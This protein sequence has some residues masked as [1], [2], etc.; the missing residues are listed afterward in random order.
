MSS[1]NRVSWGSLGL[2]ARLV[3]AA[4]NKGWAHP[5]TVQSKC[6]GEALAGNDV[7]VQ[8]RTG[9]G[10]TAAYGLALLH[11]VLSAKAE[12]ASEGVLGVVLVPTKE[13][14]EQAA[15]DLKELSGECKIEIAKATMSSSKKLLLVP[16]NNP[17]VVIGTPKSVQ[18]GIAKKEIHISSDFQMLV[19][20][21]ADLILTYGYEEAIGQLSASLPAAKQTLLMSATLSQAP[22]GDE[23][24]DLDVLK[25]QLVEANCKHP[26]GFHRVDGRRTI[27]PICTR[28]PF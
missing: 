2:D 4:S 19:L 6:I 26:S 3:V 18:E 25:S 5:T 23:E 12:A 20:D 28:V 7:L 22:M 9:S 11:S 21:E 8:A 24:S 17:E 27:D 10:K 1:K 14:I 16:N 13:L 15:S